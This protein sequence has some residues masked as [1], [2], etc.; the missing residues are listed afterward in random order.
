MSKAVNRAAAQ[1]YRGIWHGLVKW[2]KV[3]D[4]PPTLPTSPGEQLERFKP[5]EGFLRYLLLFF[6]I[7]LVIIDL[8]FLG[9]WLV[10]FAISLWLG[11]ALL[12]VF[13]AVAILPDIVVYVAIHLRYDTTWY[14]LSD[15]SVRIRRGIWTITETTITFENVQDVKIDQG[16][17]QRVYGISDIVI[18]TAGGGGASAEHHGAGTTTHI[19]RIEGI[20]DAARIRDLIMNRVRRSRLAGLGDEHK[21]NSG[22]PA[23]H[24]TRWTAG[25]LEMLREIRVALSELC[26]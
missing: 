22:H 19:G 4:E 10:S 7:G 18:Q 1:V 20:A 5:A 15:R 17:I 26:L 23:T 9:I 24:I 3:P 8:I 13:L 2:F 25:H 11:L 14:V 12:P 16:P 21:T 6:W